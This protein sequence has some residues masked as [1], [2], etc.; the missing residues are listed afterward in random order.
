MHFV[1]IMKWKSLLQAECVTN[2]TYENFWRF[3]TRNRSELS[4]V[5]EAALTISV[6]CEVVRFTASSS[7]TKTPSI[8][9]AANVYRMSGLV[10]CNSK[11]RFKLSIPYKKRRSQW[12]RG[13]R[14]RSTA[15][16]LLRLW[17]RIPPGA[18]MFGL[19]CVV[20]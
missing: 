7:A 5:E 3:S 14:R 16:R 20:R 2:K 18:W 11:Y 13:L 1:Q 6:N 9:K 4:I 12:P 10:D 15:A 8:I 17:V 19:L